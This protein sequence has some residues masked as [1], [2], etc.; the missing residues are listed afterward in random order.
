MKPTL[1]N[2]L[3]IYPLSE[4]AVTI[5][6]GNTFEKM[7][8]A[9]VMAFDRQLINKPFAGMYQTVSAHTTLTVF[10]DPIEIIY[11]NELPGK[12]CFEKVSGYLKG[13]TDEYNTGLSVEN[14]IITIPTAVAA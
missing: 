11:Q 7:V 1:A 13:L 8:M 10:F 12:N 4:S 9:R 5:E 14:D 3:A 2:D 6:F